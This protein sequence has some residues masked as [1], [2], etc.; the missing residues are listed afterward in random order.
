MAFGRGIHVAG[1]DIGTTSC[2]CARSTSTMCRPTRPVA[3]ATV[4][5]SHNQKGLFI[6]LI[7]RRR[8]LQVHVATTTT[9]LIVRPVRRTYSVSFCSGLEPTPDSMS[10]SLTLAPMTAG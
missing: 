7:G 9:G 6:L 8:M 5:V 2:P 4:R 1:R 3:P 10:H